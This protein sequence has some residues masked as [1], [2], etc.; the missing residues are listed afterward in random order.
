MTALSHPSGL[1]YSVAV[2]D[3]L[4]IDIIISLFSP[5]NQLSIWHRHLYLTLWRRCPLPDM[6]PPHSHHSCLLM[7]YQTHPISLFIGRYLGPTL[8]LS[9]LGRSLSNCYTLVLVLGLTYFSNVPHIPSCHW[10][11]LLTIS[12][13]GPSSISIPSTSSSIAQPLSSSISP[14]IF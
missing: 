9:S 13:A 10:L 2:V 14:S 3:N 6:P 8:Q 4:T 1:E 5:S 12:S 7:N 11:P